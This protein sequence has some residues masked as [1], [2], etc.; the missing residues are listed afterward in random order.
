MRMWIVF[1]ADLIAFGIGCI[2]LFDGNFFG[3][4]QRVFI[5]IP[6]K[7]TESLESVQFFKLQHL[8]CNKPQITRIDQRI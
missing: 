4:I 8:K 1:Q 2:E 5:D 6:V 7:I 3:E